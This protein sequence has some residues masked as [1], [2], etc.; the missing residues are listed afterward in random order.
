MNCLESFLH[1]LYAQHVSRKRTIDQ[2]EESVRV[3]DP[4]PRPM[5]HYKRARIAQ[6]E[7]EGQLS[8]YRDLQGRMRLNDNLQDLYTEM[9][10]VQ[11]PPLR[12]NDQRS[13]R[14]DEVEAFKLKLA[15]ELLMLPAP[16]RPTLIS[17]SEISPSTSSSSLPSSLSSSPTEPSN[18]SAFFLHRPSN[19]P[20]EARRPLFFTE[21][22]PTQDWLANVQFEAKREV[23]IHERSLQ[24]THLQESTPEPE[25]KYINQDSLDEFQALLSSFKLPRP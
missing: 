16:T 22:N 7:R 1:S 5:V 13:I 24:V 3:P 15:L 14:P 18:Q 17:G 8:S 9:N 21:P 6:A 20:I 4:S 23:V 2:V 12:M 19:P 11:M 10:V 25:E